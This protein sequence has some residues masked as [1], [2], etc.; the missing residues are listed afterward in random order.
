ME[1]RRLGDKIVFRIDSG[2]FLVESI[3]AVCRKH[4]VRCGW[5][6]GIGASDDLTIGLFETKTKTY[7]KKTL[8]GDHE[9]T[10]LLGNISRM[11]EKLYLH[12][13]ITVCDTSNHAFCGHLDEA[14][15]SATF[16]G[17]IDIIDGGV[18]RV[19]DE[20]SGLNLICFE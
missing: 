11:D 5:V 14:K 15:I 20:K 7:H 16:E 13:H 1:S 3:K 19:F 6:S 9:I 2:E 18:S 12:L 8:V 4:E 17:C 10:P